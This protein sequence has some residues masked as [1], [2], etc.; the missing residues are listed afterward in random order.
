MS[1]TA[2]LGGA[3]RVLRRHARAAWLTAAA[4][5]L[6]NTVPD[7]VRQ[8]LVWDD[9]SVPHAV[10]VDVVGFSTALVAQ[11]WLTGALA[12]LPTGDGVRPAGA[13]RRGTG[14]AVRAVRR[15]PAAVL[16]GVLTGGAVSALITVP[17]SVAALGAA[18]VLG[19][20]DDPSAGA[21]AVAAVS[22]VL[23]SWVTLPWLAV[24]LVLAGSATGGWT[25]R[26]PGTRSG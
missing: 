13:L 11:L 16:A 12:G 17:A 19:P 25:E 18:R 5:T 4:V 2:V 1:P 22:D 3:W 20:L 21:F 8:V 24:V 10:L 14:L 9:P 7:V 15:A 23:A 6:L 26:G